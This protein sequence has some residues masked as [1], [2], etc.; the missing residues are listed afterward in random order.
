MLKNLLL[1]RLGGFNVLMAALLAYFASKGYIMMALA[2]DPTGICAAIALMFLVVWGSSAKQA[3]TTAKGL[4][5]LKGATAPQKRVPPA[6]KP[7]TKRLVKIEHI[8]KAAGW[9]AYIGLIG[10]MIGFIIAIGTINPALMATASGVSALVPIMLKGMGVA[11][12]TTLTGAFFGFWTEVNHM[13][14][15]TATHCLVED[16]KAE[17]DA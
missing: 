11:V 15:H 7:W 3:W 10:T 13:A 16:E 8:H 14:I 2:A 6:G 12:W 5:F 17:W 9:M 4:N 1:Y